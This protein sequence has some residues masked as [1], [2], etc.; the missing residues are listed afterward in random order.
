ME[1]LKFE[2]MF[3]EVIE[4]KSIREC[5]KI[6]GINRNTFVE[7]CKQIF[8]EGSENMKK[9]ERI[10]VENKSRLQ[11]KEI[12]EDK[13]ESAVKDFLSGEIK[14]LT[15]AREKFMKETNETID[16]LTFKERMVEYINASNNIKLK[17]RYI[18]YEANKSGNY[19]HINFKAL[20]IEMIRHELSQTEISEMYNI[21]KR[22][23]SRELAKLE[24]NEKYEEIYFIA[25]EL[26]SRQIYRGNSKKKCEK[27]F[28]EF[29]RRL[30]DITLRSFG[31]Q[32]VI[33]G[34]PKTEAQIRYEKAK[35]LLEDVA[36]T[37]LTHQEAAKKLGVSVSTIRRAGKTVEGYE[38]LT[39]KQDSDDERK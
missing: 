14:T 8:P 12:E 27:L 23:V 10:L 25:K 15:K 22:T 24:N 11:K 21:P 5:E 3:K 32:E 9:L 4:G 35:K 16:P 36:N 30:I 20:F 7:M 1:A 31:H 39:E 6:Y 34:N 29:E 38:K 37:N 13:F 18:R 26:S 19:S 28:S 17:Q 33:I 2:E